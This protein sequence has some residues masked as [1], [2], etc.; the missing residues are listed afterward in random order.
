MSYLSLRFRVYQ[1]S[2]K[3]TVSA[4]AELLTFLMMVLY[5]AIPAIVFTALVSLSIIEDIREPVSTQALY[6]GLY[7]AVTYLLIRIQ[8]KAIMGGDNQLYFATLPVSPVK[9][10][11]VSCLIAAVAGNLPLLMPLYLLSY[12]TSTEQLVQHAHFV[13]FSIT[14]LLVAVYCITRRRPPIFTA[15]FIV[16]VVTVGEISAAFPSLSTFNLS[17]LLVLILE[18]IGQKALEHKVLSTLKIRAKTYWQL[19]AIYISRAPFSVVIRLVLICIFLALIAFVQ[20][21]LSK[22]A[23]L[24]IQLICCY[25]LGLLIGSL[26]FEHQTFKKKYHYYLALAHLSLRRCLIQETVMA[27]FFSLLVG[28][29][30]MVWLNFATSVLVYMPLMTFI[31][32]LS[33]VKLNKSFFIPSAFVAL[34]I[35]VF[36]LL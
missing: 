29:L 21:K 7:L 8:K 13:L 18:F 17:L 15:L 14:V 22:I 20:L 26:Q 36:H 31:T 1:H 11:A 28:Y 10:G 34:T 32:A 35:V 33:V 24:E 23:T 30:M 2:V 12:V 27:L 4:L 19:R 6:Q 16:T 5:L 25:V 3:T 9:S